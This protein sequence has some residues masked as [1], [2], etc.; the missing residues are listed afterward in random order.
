MASL[1]SAMCCNMAWFMD[2][3]WGWLF[4]DD[5]CLVLEGPLAVLE[6]IRELCHRQCENCCSLA[7]KKN[8]GWLGP[9]SGQREPS[10][11][12]DTNS[13][14]FGIRG[15]CCWLKNPKKQTSKSNHPSCMYFSFLTH[16][17]FFWT[18]EWFGL[19]YTSS[20]CVC[21]VSRIHYKEFLILHASVACAL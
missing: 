18:A 2:A 6:P 10:A 3:C 9:G 15:F 4:L 8:T 1:F 20:L 11:N 14:G 17:W 21:D 16:T 19:W 13:K 5:N 12:T 7:S